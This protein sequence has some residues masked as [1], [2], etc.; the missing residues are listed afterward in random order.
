M[1]GP[2]PWTGIY[3][4]SSDRNSDCL[5]APGTF[6]SAPA[7]RGDEHLRFDP[8]FRRSAFALPCRAF[9]LSPSRMRPRTRSLYP[10]NYRP[11]KD[12]GCPSPFSASVADKV[13]VKQRRRRFVSLTQRET[14]CDKKI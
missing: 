5:L 6:P 2:L 14:R 8:E 13:N 3:A 9:L 4:E 12:D 1:P 7:S 10:L 11:R